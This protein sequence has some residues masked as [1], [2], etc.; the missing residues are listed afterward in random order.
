MFL[1][2]RSPVFCAHVFFALFGVPAGAIVVVVCVF[3]FDFIHIGFFESYLGV[4]SMY[5]QIV[6]FYF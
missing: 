2:A 5:L 1:V 6:F 4:F 3:F